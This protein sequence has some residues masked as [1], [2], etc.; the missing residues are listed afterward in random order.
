MQQISEWIA[1]LLG[2]VMDWCYGFLKNY[3]W[4]ILLFTFISKI[5]LLPISVWVQKNS[6]KMVEIQP[7]VNR[8]KAKYYGDADT[9]A[10]KQAEMYKEKGYHPMASLLPLFLQ[11]VILMGVVAVIRARIPPG[12]KCIFLA[13]TSLSFRRKPSERCW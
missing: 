11:I 10:E 1:A 5:I 2:A 3:G 13:S 9:I 8:I 6:I 12:R 7:A 4:A